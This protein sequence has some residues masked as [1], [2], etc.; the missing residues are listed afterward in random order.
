MGEG[1][2]NFFDIIVILI[3]FTSAIFSFFKGFFSELL[4]LLS[5]IFAAVITVILA[6]YLF[7]YTSHW[8]SH[9]MLSK[10]L[11]FIICFV[12]ALIIMIILSHIVRHHTHEMRRGA[13]DK[14]CGV[15]F[16]LIR[17]VFIVSLVYLF[18]T[19]LYPQP[20]PEEA[21]GSTE[22]IG[23]A[24]LS[25]SA[26]YNTLRKGAAII[27]NIIPANVVNR[28]K[29]TELVEETPD[30]KALDEAPQEVLEIQPSEEDKKI[31]EEEFK[32][33]YE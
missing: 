21:D 25:E 15:I 17:G 28:L 33:V 23:P 16:G 30:E 5:W 6:P 31:I 9:E 22:R 8:I 3:V 13:F 29:R 11:A 26:S 18:A 27:Q 12:S 14:C 19:I 1:Y 2:L 7:E 32:D 10:G 24:W 4:S 20:G